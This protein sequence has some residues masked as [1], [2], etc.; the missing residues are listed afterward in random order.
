MTLAV[1]PLVR[2]SDSGR[3]GLTLVKSL[4]RGLMM[5][6]FSVVRNIFWLM[7][8]HCVKETRSLFFKYKQLVATSQSVRLLTLFLYRSSYMTFYIDKDL[9]DPQ[10]QI[11]LFHSKKRLQSHEKVTVLIVMFVINRSLFTHISNF[12]LRICFHNFPARL[13]ISSY[14]NSCKG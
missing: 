4:L 10:M 12:I 13:G 1:I 7:S 9:C 6:I 5:R 2:H 3:V 11:R 8:H 14:F